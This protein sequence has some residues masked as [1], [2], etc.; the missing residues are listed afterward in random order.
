MACFEWKRNSVGVEHS[1]AVVS[2][3]RILQQLR[4]GFIH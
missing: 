1:Q 4:F 3:L 2:V